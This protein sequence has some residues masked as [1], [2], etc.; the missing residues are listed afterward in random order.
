MRYLVL[1]MCWRGVVAKTLVALV[2]NVRGGPLAWNSL[3]DH[4]LRPNGADLAILASEDEVLPPLLANEASGRVWRMPEYEDWGECLD[5]LAGNQTWRRHVPPT[6]GGLFGG[7]EGVPGSGLIVLCVRAWLWRRLERSGLD[8]YDQLVVARTDLYYL[9]PVPLERT[10]AIVIPSG[11]DWHGGFYDRW[12]QCPARDAQLCLSPAYTLLGLRNPPRSPEEL[13]RLHLLPHLDRV[14]RVP[15][16]FALVATSTD[17]TRWRSSQPTMVRDG[18]AIKYTEEYLQATAACG[19]P[20]YHPTKPIGLLSYPHSGSHATRFLL[21]YVTGRTTAGCLNNPLDVPIAHNQFRDL[22]LPHVDLER[23][24]IALKYHDTTGR[25]CV[26]YQA[27]EECERVLVVFRDPVE[28]I[29]SEA[30]ELELSKWFE[31]LKWASGAENADH[32][33]YDTIVANPRRALRA[34][35]APLRDVATP[36]LAAFERDAAALMA[37]NRDGVEARA[38]DVP[39]GSDDLHWGANRGLLSEVRARRAMVQREVARLTPKERALWETFPWAKPFLPNARTH[40][41]APPTATYQAVAHRVFVHQNKCGGS[42]VKQGSEAEIARHPE[43]PLQKEWVVG[44]YGQCARSARSCAYIT[45]FRNPFDRLISA[46]AYCESGVADP[47]CDG[48]DPDLLRWAPTWRRY[49]D[50]QFTTDRLPSWCQ[51]GNCWSRAAPSEPI[52]LEETFAA[53][54]LMEDYD[55]SMR[56]FESVLGVPAGSTPRQGVVDVA[57]RPSAV[58]SAV[59]RLGRELRGEW[60]RYGEAAALYERQESISLTLPR[61]PTEWAKQCT[62]PKR[63]MCVFANRPHFAHTI[64]WLSG[65]AFDV[66]VLS[67]G[68]GSTEGCMGSDAIRVWSTSGPHL[69]TAIATFAEI[70]ALMTVVV[71]HADEQCRSALYG[72]ADARTYFHAPRSALWLPLG[73]HVTFRSASTRTGEPYLFNLIV[74]SSTNPARRRLG[75]ALQ[76]LPNGRVVVS[77]EIRMVPPAEYAGILRRSYFTLCPAGNNPESH[78]VYEAIE[79]GSIPVML[80]TH[81]NDTCLESLSPF[82]GAPF[83]WLDT[84]EMEPL[85]ERMRSYDAEAIAHQ[86]QRL[87]AWYA[88]WLAEHRQQWMDLT[89]RR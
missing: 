19:V 51:D 34:A 27:L 10:D 73:P 82:E 32:L 35:L 61:T 83:L 37:A 67:D 2:G 54:G 40:P 78:R 9:C 33:L 4:L 6:P 1:A 65:E 14:Q 81:P 26:Q 89:G 30:V 11:T 60:R 46:H 28:A 68:V 87:Q 21:E 39:V 62:R 80:R 17:R 5:E 25:H 77:D 31:I 58:C 64:Q 23:P 66:R 53:I 43:T 38:W 29:R 70:R 41:D 74:R 56:R 76:G 69:A 50:Q 85:V 88:A 22:A 52:D 72:L 13:L 3:V 47:I 44:G 49:T 7:L 12:I 24:P 84:W 79:S 48:W 15:L 20:A 71:L 16:R 86:R 42:S 45:M 8:A 55:R 63:R 18:T 59:D 36:G 57:A 75:L